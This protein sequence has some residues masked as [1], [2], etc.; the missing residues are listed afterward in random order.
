MEVPPLVADRFGQV[1]PLG[2][3]WGLRMSSP[4]QRA[5][6]NRRS[7]SGR[8]AG[9]AHRA[10]LGIRHQSTDRYG[11]P[12]RCISRTTS[13]STASGIAFARSSGAP[14]SVP[15]VL[16]HPRTRRHNEPRSGFPWPG[17]SSD[18]SSPHRPRQS[19]PR[20]A[21]EDSAQIDPA[22]LRQMSID[23]SVP[24]AVRVQAPAAADAGDAF[25][26]RARSLSPC[27]C[28]VVARPCAAP[29][30]VQDAE[31]WRRWLATVLQEHG[32]GIAILEIALDRE[33]AALGVFAIKLAATEARSARPAIRIALGGALVEDASALSAVYTE[34]LAPYIDLLV[35]SD[36]A[37]TT[38]RPIVGA[39]R[40]QR[41]AGGRRIAEQSGSR[42][43]RSHG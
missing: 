43:H 15:S 19:V 36:A 27:R 21:F 24:I 5:S 16:S 35:V 6:E 3:G 40:F 18:R 34:D 37:A 13:V 11:C 25:G 4:R 10:S 30:S 14:A 29:A 42:R 38:A 32:D 12:R 1:M 20:I 7:K 41:G 17:F 23:V 39:C 22:R 31:T 9:R 26:E 33:Q 2:W 28:A 8:H